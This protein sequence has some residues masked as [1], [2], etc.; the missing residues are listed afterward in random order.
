M[1]QL[2]TT[3]KE[4]YYLSFN[5]YDFKVKICPQITYRDLMRQLLKNYFLNRGFSGA[6]SGK[7]CLTYTIPKVD[8]WGVVLDVS[9]DYSNLSKLQH[10]E[11]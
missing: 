4:I 6:S 3:V 2:I 1:C 7:N 11:C 8:I 10:H 9:S 5:Q